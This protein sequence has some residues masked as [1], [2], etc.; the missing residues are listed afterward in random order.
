MAAWLGRGG[1]IL[2]QRFDNHI[3]RGALGTQLSL[4]WAPCSGPSNHVQ[5]SVPGDAQTGAASQVSK[6]ETRAEYLKRLEM[7]P[8]ALPKSLVDMAVGDMAECCRRLH[9]TRCGHVEEGGLA[10]ALL[11]PTVSVI[12][13]EGR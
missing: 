10:G 9:N 11:L 3:S 6:R 12:S 2:A 13:T 8:T 1:C 7:V 4:V 5:G